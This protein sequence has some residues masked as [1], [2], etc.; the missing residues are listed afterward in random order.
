MGGLEWLL[1]GGDVGGTDGWD[2]ARGDSKVN[3]NS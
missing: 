3:S 2:Y 1:V